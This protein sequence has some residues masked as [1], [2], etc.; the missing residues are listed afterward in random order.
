ISY[1]LK[2]DFKILVKFYDLRKALKFI[3]RILSRVVRL[4]F[5]A[6]ARLKYTFIVEIRRRVSVLL[7]KFSSPRKAGERKRR[8]HD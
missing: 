4:N 8:L 3:A 2:F 6:I 5:A 7:F 1:P